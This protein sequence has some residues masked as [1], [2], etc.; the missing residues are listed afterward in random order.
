ML[1]PLMEAWGRWS[2]KAS[3][4][5]LQFLEEDGLD[6]EG[7]ANDLA[8]AVA[9]NPVAGER[10]HLKNHLPHASFMPV[11]QLFTLETASQTASTLNPRRVEAMG[12]TLELTPLCGAGQEVGQALRGLLSQFPVGSGIQFMMLGDPR[13]QE[14]LGHYADL[15]E[16]VPRYKEMAIRRVRWYLK[17]AYASLFPSVSYRLKKIR[18]IVSVTMPV[19]DVHD[20]GAMEHLL[21]MRTTFVGTLKT[22]QMQPRIWTADDWLLWMELYA[23]PQTALAQ[24]D[25][26]QRAHDPLA[27]L[28]SQAMHGDTICLIRPKHL[29]FG[30]DPAEQ[31]AMRT[32]SVN[33]YPKQFRIEQ[34]GMMIGDYLRQELQYPSP[35][36]VCMGIM[37]LDFDAEKSKGTL[38]SA[39]ATTNADSPMARFMG[40]EFQE[41]KADW[42]NAMASFDRGE[43]LV[44]LYHQVIVFDKADQ[45]DRAERAV[46]AIWRSRSFRTTCDRYMQFQAYLTCVPMALTPSVQQDLRA[47]ERF[48]TKTLAN[49]VD[50]A[51][52]VG[53]WTGFGQ[54][55]LLLWGRLG[56]YMAIDTFANPEGNY[57]IAMAAG[58]GAGKSVLANEL[59]SSVRCQGGTAYVIDAGR[60]YENACKSH[61]GQFI[62]FTKDVTPNFN[63]FPMMED[64]DGD[65]DAFKDAVVMIAQ[66]VN[67]MAAPDRL[68]DDYSQGI[69]EEVVQKEILE[70]GRAGS[71]TNIYERLIGFKNN[72]TGEPDPVAGQLAQAMR[73]YT[74]QGIFGNHFEGSDP[75]ELKS[76]FVV[77]ELDGLAASPRL[78]STVL[79]ILMFRI[80]QQMY[81]SRHLRK[82]VLIDEAWALM[83]D[84]ATAKFIETGYRRARKYNGQFATITQSF[85]DYFKTSAAKAAYEN[86]D[87]KFSLRQSEE[88]WADTFNAS[89]FVASDGQ[90][91]VLRS[92]RTE[93]GMYSEVFVKMPQGWGVGRLILDPYSLLEYS[94]KAEDFNA[95]KAHRQQGLSIPEA[96]EAVLKERGVVT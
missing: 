33:E 90:Q 40:Q 77:L 4:R 34:V 74:R 3:Q 53:E 22:L 24:R 80:T 81:L 71:I 84:G 27:M 68:L 59:I 72:Q 95:I 78:Q 15:R 96:I 28:R 18:L 32:L 87:W 7:H 63:P 69:V 94:S 38:K 14:L 76:S 49:A 83:R 26:S 91:T 16:D 64:L 1:E 62:E 36:L 25:V 51:P 57:N 73:S 13:V 8:D 46:E 2:A 85:N 11:E 86:S 9:K 47:T 48:V 44:E 43:G 35:Y 5:V 50:T 66:I 58:S 21:A 60:S 10:I 37:M 41:K 30:D 88:T 67:S 82:I 89:H 79:M 45:I 39:R 17:G 70:R 52:L 93:V 65:E 55:S 56:Q 61:D 31:V 29:L 92:L 19:A 6:D 75:I 20:R 42:L 54:A 23:N 12:F